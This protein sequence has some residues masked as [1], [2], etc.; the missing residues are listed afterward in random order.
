MWILFPSCAAALFDENMSL[1][2]SG[3]IGLLN[4]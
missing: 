3:A 2:I 4:R 1:I